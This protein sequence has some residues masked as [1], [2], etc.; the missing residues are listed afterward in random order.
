MK[1]ERRNFMKLGLL[2]A[3]TFGFSRKAQ[4]YQIPKV[5]RRTGPSILQGATDDTKT[6][7]SIVHNNTEVLD[8]YAVDSAGRRRIPDFTRT[9]AFRDHNKKITKVFFSFLDVTETY[10]LQL[11][12]AVTRELLDQR[13]FQ[14]LDLT[15]PDLNF[16]ICSCMNDREHA[17]EIWQNLVAKKPDFLLFIG[18]SVYAD[19]DSPLTGA[20]P[21]HLWKRFCEARCTLEIYY[22]PRLIPIFATWDDHDFGLNDTNSVD[23][24]YVKESQENFLHF[25]AQDTSHCHILEKGPGIASALKF[26][27]Q[28]IVL[29]DDRSFRL[30]R[31]SKERYG[32]WGLEQENW[33]LKKIRENAGPTWLM[34]GSQFF[35]NVPWKES[36]S[37]D[38]PENFKGFL[39]ELKQTP[40][41]VIF[42]SG[43]VHY[44][45]I[46]K[47]EKEALGYETYELTSSSIHSR[48]IPGSPDIIPNNRR[49]A[50]NGQRNY[51]LVNSTPQEQ[52]CAVTVTS[53]GVTGE[54]RFQ[55]ALQI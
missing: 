15:K 14:T 27:N 10:Q 6:Q 17:P 43:D 48:N 8:V 28:T 5:L 24:K 29:L 9:A 20:D 42:A 1:I 2:Q 53:Y 40:R 35:P 36:L 4:A 30:R 45:E 16:A 49:I 12:N 11:V 21:S 55:L 52:G 41:K 46:S 25:F 18:D 34:N 19:S 3:V 47:I 26:S 13:E 7:F 32:H 38:H 22:S 23:F 31:G 54:A 33:V 39:E 51:L 50:G 44:S 37:G